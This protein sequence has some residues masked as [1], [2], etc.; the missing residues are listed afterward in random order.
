MLF[1]ARLHTSFTLKKHPNYKERH[2]TTFLP[3]SSVNKL[4]PR[5]KAANECY[6][7]EKA[8]AHMEHTA[9]TPYTRAY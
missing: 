4:M 9:L 1:F 5:H 2:E 8:T 6:D 3:S 7:V